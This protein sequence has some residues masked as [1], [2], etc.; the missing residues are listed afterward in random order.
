MIF[1]GKIDAT[2]PDH[3]LV[4]LCHNG[5]SPRP[6]ELAPA[7]VSKDEARNRR[8]GP[9][10][11]RGDAKHRPETALTRLL[12]MRI[13]DAVGLEHDPEKCAAVFPRDKRG[14]AFARRSCSNKELTRLR[15][16]PTRRVRKVAPIA[17][18]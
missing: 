5:L 12:T 8:R 15:L 1:S 7:S 9:H 11:S 2:F 3:A 17:G 18:S 6:E 10:G 16:R 13:T 14:N 4:L